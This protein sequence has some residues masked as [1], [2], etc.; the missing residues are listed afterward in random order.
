[1]KEPVILMIETS[2][3]CCSVSLARG[4][5][6]IAE[7]VTTTPK[8]H[9]S[10]TAVFVEEVLRE[11][12][13]TAADCDAVAV[14]EGPGSYTGLRVGVSTAKGL[15]FGASRPLIGV[16]TLDI[17]AQQGRGMADMIV[18]MIDARRMEV[19]CACF[20]SEANRLTDVEARIIGPDSFREELDRGTVLF[21]GNGAG[22]TA[23]V[24]SHPNARFEEC[25]P[26]ASAMVTPALEAFKKEEFKDVAYFEPFYLK[27]FV[28]GISTKSVL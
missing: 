27:E 15:C 6:I 9:A 23:G 28:A 11:C 17:L 14:S 22:K 5:E 10:L 13:L 7:R 20:D 16:G 18:P 21:I 12:S 2:T 4:N 1:M 26:L 3:E 8:L 19:Y 24:I 25:F